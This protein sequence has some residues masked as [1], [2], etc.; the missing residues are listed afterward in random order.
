[1]NSSE[2][3]ARK[4][5]HIFYKHVPKTSCFPGPLRKTVFSVRDWDCYFTLQ[6]GMITF[7]LI[8][9][10]SGKVNRGWLENTSRY[11]CERQGIVP[12]FVFDKLEEVLGEISPEVDALSGK[13]LLLHIRERN[14][15][16]SLN[17]EYGSHVSGEKANFDIENLYSKRR[18]LRLEYTALAS[19]AVDAWDSAVNEALMLVE[20]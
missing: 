3:L 19:A 18:E 4:L 15:K 17:S 6:L 5:A 7:Y 11:Y 13:L 2:K 14:L 20:K 16:F 8:D 9:R 10:T 1:M 12:W